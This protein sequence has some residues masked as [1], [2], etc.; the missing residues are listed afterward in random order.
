MARASRPIGLLTFRELDET[1]GLS[2]MAAELLTD[3]RTGQNSRHTL[4]AQFRQSVF[5][6]LAHDPATAFWR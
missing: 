2:G 3:T 1:L 5:G 4:I 6:R